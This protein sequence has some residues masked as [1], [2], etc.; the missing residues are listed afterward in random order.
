MLCS[1][2]HDYP[3]LTTDWD[4]TSCQLALVNPFRIAIF[5]DEQ[6]VPEGE[7]VSPY[8]MAVERQ[9]T[10][11]GYFVVL[12][13]SEETYNVI[14]ELVTPPNLDLTDVL[15][16]RNTAIFIDISSSQVVFAGSILKFHKYPSMNSRL[17]M[18][19]SESVVNYHEFIG[20]V[21]IY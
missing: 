6:I 1:N 16:K 8:S 2:Y 14:C 5:Y 4:I 19:K 18:K 20:E 13:F 11:V 12:H 7:C 15:K 17:V 21:V 9:I 10:L 3:K